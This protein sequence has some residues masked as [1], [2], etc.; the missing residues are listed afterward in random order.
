MSPLLQPRTSAVGGRRKFLYAV[1]GLGVAGMGLGAYTTYVEPHRIEV[2]ERDADP[3]TAGGMGGEEDR[4]VQRSA[5]RGQRRFQLPDLGDD[6]DLGLAEMTVFTGDFMTSL[7][8]EQI[9]NVAKVLKHLSRG[10]R[11]AW[12]FSGIMT[13]AWDGR[14]RGSQSVARRRWE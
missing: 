4:A 7:K 5:C 3:E 2:V 1:A 11:G 12:R 13:T 14:T 8:D 10:R 6:A 9:S